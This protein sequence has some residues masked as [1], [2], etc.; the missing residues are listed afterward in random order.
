MG[1]FYFY[2]GEVFVF[3]LRG[4]LWEVFGG[5]L[6]WSDGFFGMMSEAARGGRGVACARQKRS[7]VHVNRASPVH[8]GRGGMLGGWRGMLVKCRFLAFQV[9]PSAENVCVVCVEGW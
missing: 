8:V 6:V 9:Q 4:V 1:L 3:F 7:P 5:C 2:F